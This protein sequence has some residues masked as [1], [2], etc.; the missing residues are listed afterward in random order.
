[1][2]S[3]KYRIRSSFIGATTLSNSFKTDCKCSIQTDQ[4][5]TSCSLYCL[6]LQNFHQILSTKI[7]V[8]PKLFCKKT[9][10]LG[11]V[12]STKVLASIFYLDCCYQFK[13]FTLKD[14]AIKETWLWLQDPNIAKQSSYYDMKFQQFMCDLSLL[15]FGSL[16]LR[17]CFRGSFQVPQSWLQVGGYAFQTVLRIRQRSTSMYLAT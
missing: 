17:I 13:A 10:N 5:M 7:W 8:S 11:Q 1:M 12:G 4:S 9:L 14:V 6:A 15:T 16:G 2:P 3:Q